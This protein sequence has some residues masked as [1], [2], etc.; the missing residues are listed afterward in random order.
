MEV[1]IHT[2]DSI[3]IVQEDIRCKSSRPLLKHYNQALPNQEMAIASSPHLLVILFSIPL[4]TLLPS[5]ATATDHIVGANH[6]WN[7]GINYTLWAN[8]QTFYVG[9]LICTALPSPP[10]YLSAFNIKGLD[11]NLAIHLIFNSN[12]NLKRPFFPI[13]ISFLT[14]TRKGQRFSP[15]SSTTIIC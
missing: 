6:G 8:N 10:P 14:W 7:P 9:D 11:P 15:S 5:P 4:A 2:P 13:L 1:R 3:H 12:R